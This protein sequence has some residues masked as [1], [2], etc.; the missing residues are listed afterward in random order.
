MSGSHPA[1]TAT[2][3]S[4]SSSASVKAPHKVLVVLPLVVQLVV[5]R[6]NLAVLASYDPGLGTTWIMMIGVW[7]LAIRGNVLT[8]DRM[9][10]KLHWVKIYW[11][12]VAPLCG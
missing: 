5:E 4:R 2:A 3:L 9:L 10:G 1:D 8:R 11:K 12:S 6:V 7:I